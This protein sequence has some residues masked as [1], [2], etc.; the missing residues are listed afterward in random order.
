MG[1]LVDEGGNDDY[2]A[3]ADPIIFDWAGEGTN[4]SGS[5]GFAFGFR[6][7]PYWS[8][9]LGA[10]LDLA[11]D[12][13]YQCAVMCLGF[14]YFFG[15]GLFYDAAGDD[16]YTNTHKYTMGSATHQSVGLFIDGQGADVYTLEGDDEAIGL[17]Y[18]HGVAFHIDRGDEDDVYTVE[19]I[20][21]FVLGF[22]RHPALGVLLNEGGNDAYHVPGNGKRSLG[23]TEV[24]PGDRDGPGQGILT[25]GLFLDLGGAEDL[26]DVAREEVVNGG[27]WRQ[28][29]PLGGAWDPKL[30]FGY[31]LDSD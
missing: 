13:T 6:L 2:L 26:Y 22:A 25:V 29:E 21:D 15:T 28:E 27:E 11:G 3:I 24:N 23:R 7:G 1:W 12:D 31:G 20:G 16:R 8:G 18:D 4:F 30:D 9:G 5:Q 19:N 10:L 17:G 14:G